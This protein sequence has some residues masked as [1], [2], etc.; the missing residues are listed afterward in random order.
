[1]SKRQLGPWLA[2]ENG[3]KEEHIGMWARRIAPRYP[4]EVGKVANVFFDVNDKVW[5][6][7]LRYH[8]HAIGDFTATNVYG[9][10][11]VAEERPTGL[12]LLAEQERALS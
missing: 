3:L 6:A 10:W 5:S 4:V 11:E 7:K 9:V 8:R 12:R 2:T 1:M